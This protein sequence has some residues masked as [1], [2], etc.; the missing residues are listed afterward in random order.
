MR[1]GRRVAAHL[2]CDRHPQPL[3][4]RVRRLGWP[5]PF[6]HGQ[7]TP[8][9]WLAGPAHG[10]QR[11][12]RRRRRPARVRRRGQ[13]QRAVR[14]AWSAGEL[15]PALHRHRRQRLLG[16]EGHRELHAPGR[17][18][19]VQRFLPP[20][21]GLHDPL[22]PRVGLGS[23]LLPR[24]QHRGVSETRPGQG[25]HPGLRRPLCPQR[26]LHSRFRIARGL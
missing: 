5:A 18:G 11:Q 14:K 19:G 15:R 17:G 8:A 4:R 20:R 3:F 7:P 6:Q 13:R 1:R 12:G 25:L 9:R 10:G 24:G 21:P 16:V 2:R 26:V 22:R 23:Q